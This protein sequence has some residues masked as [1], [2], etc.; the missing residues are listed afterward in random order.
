MIVCGR[1]GFEY[2]FQEKE[3]GSGRKELVKTGVKM[4]AESEFGYEPSLLVHMERASDLKDL[5]KVHREASILKDR[6][7]LRC[8][9]SF[10]QRWPSNRR[11]IGCVP[12]AS[13]H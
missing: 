13:H 3:D 5:S 12:A 9:V 2:D 10:S 4:K 11:A 7:A 8:L 6:G 1:A